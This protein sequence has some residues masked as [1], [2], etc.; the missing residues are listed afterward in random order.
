MALTKVQADG[1]NLGDTFA[2]TGTVTGA[3]ETSVAFKVRRRQN[4][5][6][7]TQITGSDIFKTGQTNGQIITDYNLGSH[8]SNGRFTCPSDG[9]Y[10]FT[11]IG[12]IADSSGAVAGGNY[13]LIAYFTKNGETDS[14]SIDGVQ[15]YHYHQSGN[16]GGYPYFNYTD[17]YQLSANDVIGFRIQTGGFYANNQSNY[18][19]KFMGRKL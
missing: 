11:I 15:M 17:T 5:G 12:L 6:S 2:F 19:A 18:A 7:Q 16:A 9:L 14:D 10:Q 13:T 1:I 8:F 4:A 3:G